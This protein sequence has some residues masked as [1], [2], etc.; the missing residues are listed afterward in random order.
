MTKTD[1]VHYILTIKDGIGVKR[2]VEIYDYLT[3]FGQIKID[4]ETINAYFNY[5][6]NRPEEDA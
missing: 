1:A 3:G 2:A 6:V 5:D 4:R